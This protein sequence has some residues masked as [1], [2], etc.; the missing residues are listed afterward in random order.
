MEYTAFSR[1]TP[2][3][4]KL[5]EFGF[6]QKN[7]KLSYQR[8]IL[9]GQFCV[10]VQ[11]VDGV[12]ETQTVDTS[13]GEVYALHLI[14]DSQGAFIGKVRDAFDNLLQ[15][16]ADNCFEM[17]VFQSKTSHGVIEFVGEKFGC[18]LEFLWEKFS[19]N[20]IWRRKDTNK[21][22]GLLIVLSK[23]KLGL[24]NDEKIDALV[25]RVASDKLEKVVDNKRIFPGYHMN[26]KHWITIPLDGTVPLEEICK[27]VE[28]S[29][30]LAK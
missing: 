5:I 12:V 6:A 17:D 23:K 11:I 24:D 2:N 10:T 26:K 25:I 7:G 28:Q 8:E 19:D 29:Y 22:F 18:E 15:E 30:E 13:T 4:K 16:V 21:W 27:Y 3:V 9:D 1:K 20:A 14:K